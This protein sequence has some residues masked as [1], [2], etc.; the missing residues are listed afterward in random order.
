MDHTRP[1][2]PT[3]DTDHAQPLF[4]S[5]LARFRHSRKCRLISTT[6]AI[7]AIALSSHYVLTRFL[8]A[9]RQ[10]AS[11]H[12]QMRPG[13]LLF[14]FFVTIIC[15][16]LGGIIWALVLR[17]VGGAVKWQVCMHSHLLANIGGY[18]PGYGWKF[19]G[20]A[21]LV[22]CE[23]VPMRLVSLAV[24]LEFAGLAATR[25][26]IAITT[27]PPALL[28]DLG[29]N[30][31]I[32]HLWWLRIGIWVLLLTLPL[33][34]ERVVLWLQSRDR[35]RWGNLVIKKG[36]LWLALLIMCF[37]WS[38]YG[39]GHALL[40]Q[41]LHNTAFQQVQGIVFSTT[42]SFLISLL[43]F[44]V[45]GGIGIRES[46]L[47]YTLEST[48]PNVIVTVSAL[49]SRLVLLLAEAI[50]ALVGSWMRHQQKLCK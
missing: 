40:I 46:V 8:K 20:K 48:F 38:L 30:A 4:I 36:N 7:I 12:L 31:V 27:L 5:K 47:I 25:A 29:W 11:L 10:I 41:S 26:V 32:P 18:L 45:P 34:L 17:G 23:G 16:S 24:L 37:T 49:M 43:V 14:S 6:L 28:L 2:M 3:S 19:V 39:A 15:V 35:Q 21:Y 42:V 44:F 22:Q 1:D 13:L 33:V 9:I 50:G